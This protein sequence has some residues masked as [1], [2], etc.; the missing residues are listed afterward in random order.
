VPDVAFGLL[1]R[2]STGL[3]GFGGGQL[4]A[5]APGLRKT[6]GNRLLR[7]SSAMLAFANVLHLFPDELSRLRGWRFAFSRILTRALDGPLFRHDGLPRKAS[8]HKLHRIS[9][10]FI[11]FRGGPAPS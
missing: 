1:A 10:W 3:T 8:L 6:D 7:G 9:G 4:D 5:S 11:G 2:S